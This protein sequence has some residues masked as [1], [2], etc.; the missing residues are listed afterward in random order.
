MSMRVRVRVRRAVGWNSAAGNAQVPASRLAHV[1]PIVSRRDSW[2]LLSLCFA[3]RNLPRPILPANVLSSPSLSLMLGTGPPA[4]PMVGPVRPALHVPG[5]ERGSGFH[6]CTRHPA[7]GLAYSRCL[8][9]PGKRTQ[10]QQS[11]NVNCQ[12]E[13]ERRVRRRWVRAAQEGRGRS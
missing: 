3:P 7:P 4:G 8:I 13:A 11:R 5:I 6:F 1:L 10:R 9:N 12:S 2:S